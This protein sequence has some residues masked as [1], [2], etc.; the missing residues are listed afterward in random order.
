MTIWLAVLAIYLI[1]FS[2]NAG[3]LIKTSYQL[4]DASIV[5]AVDRALLIDTLPSAAQPAGNAWAARMLGVGSVIGFFVCVFRTSF[6]A[7]RLTKVNR[8]NIELP[9]L[10]PFL[11]K[12]QL[13]V[14]SVIVSLLLFAG[15]AVMVVLVKERILLKDN[16]SKT[17]RKTFTQELKDMWFGML[18]LPPVIRKI[19][20]I[21]PE[22]HHVELTPTASVYYSIL[23]C[24]LL[25]N[26]FP[27]TQ[28]SASLGWFPILFYTT[29]YVGDLYKN[30]VL[31]ASPSPLSDQDRAALDAEATRFGSRALFYSSLVSLFCNIVLPYFVSEA[32]DVDASRRGKPGAS[33]LSSDAADRGDTYSHLER[34]PVRWRGLFKRLVSFRV[35][36]RMQVHLGSLWTLSHLVVAGCMFGT[37]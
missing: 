15:H 1:D 17:R 26:Y 24:T 5:Q 4:S 31:T 11:G 7:Q 10:L 36:R 30:A 37:L 23:V 28:I 22:Q 34:N 19:V 25:H 12:S 13:E 27:L 21:C 3:M 33:R 6:S 20:S 2:I 18:T 16:D 8:G 32:A 14:L 35:P 9:T 29:I